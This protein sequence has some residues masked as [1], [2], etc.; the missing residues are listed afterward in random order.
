MSLYPGAN[1]Q[2]P[3]NNSGTFLSGYAKKGILH[4]TEG[5]SVS[6]AVGAYTANNSWP[7]FT[8]HNGVVFQHLPINKAARSLQNLSGGIETNRG[9]A[10]QIEVVGFASNPNWP[11]A[12]VN[13]MQALMRWIEAN[14]G[15]QPIG[16]GRPFASAYGQN[17]L[18]FTNAE[19][20]SF[21]GWAGHCHVGEN[22]HWDPGFININALLPLTGPYFEVRNMSFTVPR[23]SGGYIVVGPDGGVFTYAG[24]PYYGSV[25]GLGIQAAVVGASWTSSGGGY[26]LLGSD[27]GIFGFGDAPYHGGFNSLPA[28]VKGDRVPVGLITVGNGYCVVAADPSND[29]SLFDNYC[30]G[31]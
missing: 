28:N 25:P 14:A 18:R 9:G 29:G 23:P 17:H 31:V 22:Q 12:L 20:V 11:D 24:A 8:V 19:W 2:Y 21:N 4:T 15:V 3:G 7:H 10:I 6:G 27:G 13:S 1:R 16:P 5:G 26:W 30:F